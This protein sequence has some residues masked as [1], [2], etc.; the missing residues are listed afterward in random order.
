MAVGRGRE[1][2]P[3]LRIRWQKAENCE[4]RSISVNLPGMS[5]TQNR[6]KECR[7]PELVPRVKVENRG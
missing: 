7:W 4:I 5:W 6:N 3:G 1:R 2:M